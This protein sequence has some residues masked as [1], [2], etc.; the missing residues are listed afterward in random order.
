MGLEFRYRFRNVL[1]TQ[2]CP[3]HGLASIHCVL[4]LNLIKGTFNICILYS[5][6]HTSIHLE[7]NMAFHPKTLTYIYHALILSHPRQ[8]T[9]S[10]QNQRIIG[11]YQEYQEH[12]HTH[13]NSH[14][15]SIRPKLN[16]IPIKC[17]YI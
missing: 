7:I 4:H 17:M 2:N 9:N 12:K 5:H 14:I 8:Q 16:Y 11:E 6:T 1:G 15:I 3:T 10:W 13:S